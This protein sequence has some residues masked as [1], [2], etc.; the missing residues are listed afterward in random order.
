MNKLLSIGC[1]CACVFIATSYAHADEVCTTKDGKITVEGKDANEKKS[2][3]EA[4]GGT[5]AKEKSEKPKAQSS[6]GGGW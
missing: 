3:C 1:I 4:K 5:W 2:A 6:G